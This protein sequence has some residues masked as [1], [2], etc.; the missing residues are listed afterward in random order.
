MQT[1]TARPCGSLAQQMMA[2]NGCQQA[3]LGGERQSQTEFS[4]EYVTEKP[5]MQA[6]ALDPSIE[7]NQDPHLP[8]D[9]DS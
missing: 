8:G 7:P 4:L 9:L 5:Q 1:K 3:Q 2:A 6:G